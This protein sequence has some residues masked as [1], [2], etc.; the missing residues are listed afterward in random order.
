MKIGAKCDKCGLI[1]VHDVD[2]IRMICDS[3]E[4]ATLSARGREEKIKKYDFSDLLN[5]GV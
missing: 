1:T 3:C 5:G 4:T 2:E